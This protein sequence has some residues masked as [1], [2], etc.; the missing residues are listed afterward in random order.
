[1]ISRNGNVRSH[2]DV[3]HATGF[4]SPIVLVILKDAQTID[5]KVANMKAFDNQDGVTKCL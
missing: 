2:V 1:M 3:L 4:A 5:P